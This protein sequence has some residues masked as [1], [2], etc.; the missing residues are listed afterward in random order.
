M[1]RLDDKMCDLMAHEEE[2]IQIISRF[3]LS[4]G[5]G[6]QTI[7]Q[8]CSAHG[9]HTPT[10]LAVVNHKVFRQKATLQTSI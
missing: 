10:F 7:D 5:V 6:E 3:G 8:V 2:A 1:Y 9:V 4:I